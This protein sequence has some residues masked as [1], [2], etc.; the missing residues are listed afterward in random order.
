M[1]VKIDFGR[2]FPGLVVFLIGA[3]LLIL[4][5]LL[6]LLSFFLFFVPALHGI[7][8]FSLDVL[9]ASLVLMGSGVLIMF[10]GAS[11]WGDARS[12]PR[13]TK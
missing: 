7:F 1:T 13:A 10:S 9:V 2:V 5:V 3:V 8:Y 11:G 12:Q 6:A 4:W